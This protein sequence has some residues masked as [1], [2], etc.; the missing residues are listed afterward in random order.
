MVQIDPIKPKL[1]P[2]GT[3]RFNPNCDVLLSTSAFKFNL[4]RYTEEEEEDDGSD[5]DGVMWAMLT[6]KCHWLG[7]C[8][9]VRSAGP[10]DR[11]GAGPAILVAPKLAY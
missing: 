5:G 6:R 9:A 7:P 10:T 1:K 8:E 3:K 4:R 11:D 2:P